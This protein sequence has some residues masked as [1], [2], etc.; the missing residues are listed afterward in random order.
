MIKVETKKLET[1]QKAVQD[2]WAVQA[3]LCRRSLYYFLQVVWNEISGD[4][5]RL[6]WHLEYLAKELEKV[7]YRVANEEPKEYDLIINI[8]PG[9]TKSTLVSIVYPAWCW[10]K[11]GWMKFINASY[12]GALSLE[13]AEACRTILRSETYR[14]M[15]DN[16]E[17]KLDKDTKTNFA[18]TQLVKMKDG[19]IKKKPG[20]NRFSTSVG[21]T[22]TG[23]HGH[24]IIIDDPLN[25]K[26][27]ASTTEL[28]TANNWID[29]TLS[30]RKVNK[31][32]TPI[33]IIMQ[34]LHEDDVTGYLLKK[35]GA[36]IKHICLPGEITGE[37]EKFVKPKSV[38]KYYVN[39]LLDPVRMPL[40]VLEE[41]EATLG[42]YGYA[43]QFGQNPTP[44][45]GG[46]FKVENFKLIDYIPTGERRLSV[47]RWW[48]KAGTD[49][50]SKWGKSAAYTCGV[51]MSKL[52]NG[53]FV[54]ED[55]VRGKWSTNTREDIIY[56]TAQADGIDVKI[57]HEQEPGSAGVDSAKATI[58]NLA[59]FCSYAERS[60]GSKVSRAD[61]YSVQVNNGNVWLLRAEWNKDFIEEHRLF[62][63]SKLKD[64]VDAASG[65]FSKVSKVR[66]VAGA[67][68]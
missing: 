3:E 45:K 9:T 2:P 24:Q 26:Q 8:P 22:L 56:K 57:W 59:G 1:F 46:M 50:H 54:V 33:I 42:Q 43:A 51:K 52:S 20:G 49:E 38:R 10:A 12:S 66:K 21:G 39:G 11:W 4:T 68:D 61:P 17:V 63:F 15:F 25:P 32:V 60:T 36:R 5:L 6:N 34:R 28:M 14:N 48:D 67:I 40:S 29:Q 64:Q 16:I 37:Y 30:T 62:P 47:V 55:V 7:A 35:S 27:A 53:C 31:V 18:I 65:A 58:N 13:H 19:R 41:Y 44:P 23:F